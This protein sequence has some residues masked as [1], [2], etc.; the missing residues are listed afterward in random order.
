M[1][2]E[3]GDELNTVAVGAHGFF[4]Q[5]ATKSL[6]AIISLKLHNFTSNGRARNAD[7]SPTPQLPFISAHFSKT[8]SQRLIRLRFNKKLYS[9]GV[10]ERIS[11]PGAPNRLN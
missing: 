1:A 6:A 9:G 8:T 11:I 4:H 7:Y 10:C 2:A 5:T 3:T